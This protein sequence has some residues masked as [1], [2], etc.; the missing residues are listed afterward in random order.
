MA[1]TIKHLIFLAVLIIGFVC[2][3]AI[4]QQQDFQARLG[5][6]TSGDINKKWAWEVYAGQRW[7]QNLSL[8]DKSIVQPSISY[9]ALDFL[10]LGVG[11]RM[12]WVYDSDENTRFHQRFHTN[13]AF[14]YKIDRL[15]LRYRSRLQYGFY[16][17]NT[18]D[19]F[20]SNALVHRG[21]FEA[22]YQPFGTRIKPYAALEYFHQFYETE[23]RSFVKTRYILGLEYQFTD[24]YIDAFYQ[25]DKEVNIA[26]P[27]TEFILGFKVGYEF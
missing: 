18:N 9:Q 24:C 12:S 8:A 16:D 14:K 22:S 25:I 6:E 10:S 1:K 20:R 3:D 2:Q 4:A 21:K 17:Y 15:K 13:L 5:L 11:Y 7:K 26:N 23:S 19:G 27:M